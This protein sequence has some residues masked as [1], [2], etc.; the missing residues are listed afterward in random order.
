MQGAGSG[1]SEGLGT[2]V[3]G[4]EAWSRRLIGGDGEG[5]GAGEDEERGAAAR[6]QGLVWGAG[7]D[8]GARGIEER[9]G[10]QG[11]TP[12]AGSV[13]GGT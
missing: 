2:A 11:G 3:E 4:G 8:G 13:G 1:S 6:L 5:D 7:E 12:Y 10:R 9:G